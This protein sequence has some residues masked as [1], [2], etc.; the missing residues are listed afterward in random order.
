MTDPQGISP[1]FDGP[2]CSSPVDR[3]QE[4]HWCARSPVGSRW[5][6][7]FLIHLH[8]RLECFILSMVFKDG[9]LG[10]HDYFD[11]FILLP[12]IFHSRAGSTCTVLL[13][14]SRP[15]NVVSVHLTRLRL[16]GVMKQARISDVF[17]L[18]FTLARL[19]MGQNIVRFFFKSLLFTLVFRVGILFRCFLSRALRF[20]FSRRSFSRPRQ[21][22]VH[23]EVHPILEP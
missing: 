9:E 17:V 7:N 20:S 23:S 19:D 18:L 6:I 2:L 14:L 1:C 16:L 3:S 22:H 5:S 12:L 15:P 13:A 10:F 11:I 4:W 8:E 21:R